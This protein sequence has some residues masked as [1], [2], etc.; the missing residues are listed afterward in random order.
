MKGKAGLVAPPIQSLYI[1]TELYNFAETSFSLKGCSISTRSSSLCWKD[2]EF[3]YFHGNLESMQKL[4][5]HNFLGYSSVQ[6]ESLKLSFW[7]CVPSVIYSGN[8]LV[9]AFR[10][11]G[12]THNE[13]WKGAHS[14]ELFSIPKNNHF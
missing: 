12:S 9:I 11:L 10:I 13:R 5:R 8:L 1:S 4:S 6:S 2:P 3:L 7:F 14:S